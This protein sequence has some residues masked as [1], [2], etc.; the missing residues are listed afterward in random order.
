MIR[1]L[2]TACA[3]GATLALIAAAAPAAATNDAG[4]RTANPYSM[5][6]AY[7]NLT[8]GSSAAMD[9]A[10]NNNINPT[11]LNV[12][13]VRVNETQLLNI[14]D[15]NYNDPSFTGLWSCKANS[16][17]FC[18]RADIYIDLSNGPFT[19]AQH[20]FLMCHEAG[21]HFGLAHWNDGFCMQ[22]GSY[23]TTAYG[24]HNGPHL[25]PGAGAWY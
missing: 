16:G 7:W 10:I 5:V 24:T 17:A 25:G 15:E 9:W 2:V 8:G 4:H 12:S 11:N 22:T 1:R 21:H 6:F 18:T 20:R 3:L 14:F 19:L 13:A 23:G